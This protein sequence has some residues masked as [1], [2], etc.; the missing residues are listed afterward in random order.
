MSIKKLIMKTL[1]LLIIILFCLEIEAR[2]LHFEKSCEPWGVDSEMVGL[3]KEKQEKKYNAGSLT[4]QGMIRFFQ[5]YIS[6]IDGPRSSYYPTSS[7]YTLLAIQK[8][9]VFK[10]IALGCDR[11]MRENSDT[12]VYPITSDFGPNRKLDLVR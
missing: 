6:P 10:G 9:G 2:P 8:Y 3:P 7:Q 4:C 11:L 5:N 12:W 1:Y